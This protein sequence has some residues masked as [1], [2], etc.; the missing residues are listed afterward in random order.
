MLPVI[1][2]CRADFVNQPFRGIYFEY[3]FRLGLGIS[4][5][6]LCVSTNLLVVSASHCS[7]LE[8]DKKTILARLSQIAEYEK[9]IPFMYILYSLRKRNDEKRKIPP[10]CLKIHLHLRFPKTSIIGI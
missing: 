10:H 1:F 5:E 3:S 4:G 7:R 8:K 2:F 9:F 6:V